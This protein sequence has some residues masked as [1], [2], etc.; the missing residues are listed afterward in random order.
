M[1]INYSML[2]RQPE[3][4]IYPHRRIG[5]RATLARMLQCSVSDLEATAS[6][7][8]GLYNE[9]KTRKKDGSI[10]LCYDAKPLLKG[11]Q[12]RIKC[13]ILRHVKYPSY[14]MG[15]L[16]DPELPRDFV[17]NASAHTGARVLINEDLADFFPSISVPIISDVFR[18]F[19]GFPKD[20]A[21]TLTRLTTR[22][23]CL[24]QGAKTSTYLSN[25][26]FWAHEPQLVAVLWSMGF[27]Y[28]RYIDDVTISS[29]SDKTCREL[30]R[31]LSLLSSMVT[32]YGL[33]FKRPKHRLIYAGQ[34]MEVT[35]L[36]I[37][38]DGVGL[39]HEKQSAIRELV[40]E[41]EINARRNIPTEI[42]S[43]ARKRVASLVG[44]YARLHPVPGQ[45]LRARLRAVFP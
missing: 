7:A 32:R 37:G 14:L 29:K 36:V 10:R 18:H 30:G 35:G 34:R 8:D 3:H 25:L 9:I 20:V 26:V 22:M 45:A 2:R 39:S 12:A 33:K 6:A 38:E 31:A 4:P 44:L 19:F 16:L 27:E 42:G 28:T 43:T 17:R 13:L 23:G 24:P 5:S 41:C 15:G 11:M 21:R 40:R 1:L